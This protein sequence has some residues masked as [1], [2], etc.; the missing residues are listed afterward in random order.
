MKDSK[1]PA[2]SPALQA[3]LR[4]LIEEENLHAVT[5][6]LRLSRGQCL[7]YLAGL[8]MNPATLRG[9][10]STLAEVGRGLRK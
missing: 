2:P 4:E 6:R 1:R 9:I 3:R 8:P 5:Q 10:E 7:Q